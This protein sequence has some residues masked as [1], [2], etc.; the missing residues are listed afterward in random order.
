MEISIFVHLATF[1][2]V[3][4]YWVV[5]SHCNMRDIRI[6]L[7]QKHNLSLTFN[8]DL[9]LKPIIISLTKLPIRMLHYCIQIFLLLHIYE[10]WHSLFWGVTL[11]PEKLEVAV[12]LSKRT[13][14]R[15]TLRLT[16]KI[17]ESQCKD[18]K[19]FI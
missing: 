6:W 14:P 7:M 16:F 12:R 15:Q 18:I 3:K 5:Y 2:V 19:N 17:F 11:Y 8:I 4:S 9:I 13:E 10:K 1:Q